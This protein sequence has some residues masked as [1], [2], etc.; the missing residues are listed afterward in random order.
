LDRRRNE[1]ILENLK[2]KFRFSWK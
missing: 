1:N 2:R